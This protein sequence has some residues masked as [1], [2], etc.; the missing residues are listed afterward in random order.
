V[1][2]RVEVYLLSSLCGPCTYS[3]NRRQLLLLPCSSMRTVSSHR[4]SA[5]VVVVVVVVVV[6]IVMEVLG[7]RGKDIHT[8]MHIDHMHTHNI[9]YTH[10]SAFLSLKYTRP[11]LS[12]M[13]NT[14]TREDEIPVTPILI[15]TGNAR[16]FFTCATSV[17]ND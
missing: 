16:R 3:S 14:H 8:H 9:T 17:L 13:H 15:L 6:E 5:V 1:D 10:V 2:I 12:H 7:G 11:S 4:C